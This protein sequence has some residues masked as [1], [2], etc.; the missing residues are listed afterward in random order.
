MIN[1]M[2]NTQFIESY[3]MGPLDSDSTSV[4][5]ETYP[6]DDGEVASR[7]IG[8][9]NKNCSQ[10]STRSSSTGVLSSLRWWMPELFA[11]LLSMVSFVS[12]VFVLRNNYGKAPNQIDL[13]LSIGLN[14]LVALPSTVNRVALMVPVG[15]AMSQEVWL[16]FSSTRRGPVYRARLRDLE[17]SDA[18]SRGAWGSLL[19]LFRARTRYSQYRRDFF[20]KR[21]QLTYPDRW[22]AYTGALVTISSFVFGTFTQQLIAYIEF[23]ITSGIL[24][25]KNVDHIEYWQNF[26]G[27]MAEGGE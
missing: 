7:L 9:E 23:P 6:A 25:A 10:S 18:A 3:P 17:S 21:Q 27:N 11:S 2:N 16:W 20:V 4:L 19:L 14:G 26:T 24:Q 8:S 22:L 5:H 12:L 1:V 15:S 13:P